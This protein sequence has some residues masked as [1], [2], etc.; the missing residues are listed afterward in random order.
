MF[1]NKN[2]LIVS[3]HADDETFGMGGSIFY[4]KDQGCKISW[5]VMSKVWSPKWNKEQITKRE[6]DIDT[7]AAFYDFDEVIRW[8]YPDNKMEETCLN[9]YQ[10]SMISVLETGKPDFVFCPSPWDWNT[11]HKLAFEVVEMSVKPLYSQYIQAIFAYEIP[12]ST[13]WGFKSYRQFPFNYYIDIKDH[14]GNKCK[15]CEMYTTEI[16]AFPHSRS[17]EG[18]DALAKTRGM[19]VGI[20]AAEGFH[21]LRY[22]ER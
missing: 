9:D 2:V 5:L 20:C 8:D 3:A 16:G 18:V 21:L 11:E 4:L 19:E 13:D 7:I 6:S 10:D 17:I 1:K 12:S 15:A 14:L 22:L